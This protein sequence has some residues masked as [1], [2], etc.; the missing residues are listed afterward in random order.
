[1]KKLYLG[2]LPLVCS[3]LFA[4]AADTLFLD[5]ASG[6]YIG[7]GNTYTFTESTGD[8]SL[9][10]G[11]G[12][13]AFSYNSPD[14]YV[15][16]SF[17]APNGEAMLA[18]HYLNAQRAPFNSPKRPGI[19]VSMDGRGCNTIKGDFFIHEL[20][21]N[22]ATPVVALDFVQYCGNSSAPL[23]GSI[24]MNS[25]LAAPL[26]TPVAVIDSPLRHLLEGQDVTLSGVKSFSSNSTI[27]SGQWQQITGTPITLDNPNSMTPTFTVPEQPLSGSDIT[28]RLTVADGQGL[29][30]EQDVTLPL[31]SKSAPLTYMELHSEPGDYIGQGKD[32]YFDDAFNAI[33][34]SI[35][36]DNGVSANIDA[37]S[38]WRADFAAPY[39]APL[40]AGL[41]DPAQRFAFRDAGVA[42]LDVGG[43][44]RG[45]NTISG[46]F[47]VLDIV[48]QPESVDR[49]MADFTQYCESENNPPLT[50]RLAIN[51]RHPSVPTAVAGGDILSGPNQTINLDGANSTDN[52]SITAYQWST[53]HPEITLLDADQASAQLVTPDMALGAPTIE[54][55]IILTITDD[56]GFKDEDSI[57]VI[58]E[59]NNS[60]PVANDDYV[61]FSHK[62]GVTFSPLDNDFDLDD[63][64]DEGSLEIVTYPQNG[65]A[66]VLS[67]GN[68]QYQP[69]HP[70]I[71]SDT[72]AYRVRDTASAI[73][74]P[75]TVHFARQ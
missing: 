55:T 67:N 35:N 7:G 3:P 62:Q 51:A 48:A 58:V 68:I 31:V 34:A 45:C 27:I 66:Q 30:D 9:T 49:F 72:L 52:S 64:L 4:N 44:G 36:Y 18:Q 73:S 15:R 26:P 37:G 42:G 39:D 70:S 17:V 46:S 56:E 24:R 47:T 74:Q 61:S 21:L 60:A 6:D 22:A 69:N 14:H 38:W 1:M 8:I 71:K 32:W 10:P 59:H 43:N 50:G 11:N 65:S 28:L 57:Q 20:D 40:E 41:Y 16:L 33:S 23:T 53:E 2:V 19:A 54:A 12:E 5:S 29:V 75:A 63:N 13:L 25:S